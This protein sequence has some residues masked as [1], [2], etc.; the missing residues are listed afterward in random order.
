MGD[1]LMAKVRADGKSIRTLTVKVRY[2]DMDEEQA[3]VSLEEPTDLETE[4]YAEISRLLRKAWKRRVS[5]RLVSL[6][7]ANLYDGR[8]RGVLALD[9]PARQHE[10]QQR[11]ADVV[12]ALREKYGRGVVLRGHDFIL[13]VIPP[14]SPSHEPNQP[15]K[16][17]ECGSP[18]PLLE[19]SGVRKRQGTAA[20]QDAGAPSQIPGPNA[21]PKAVEAPHEP[22]LHKDG[23][24]SL[25]LSPLEGERGP[26]AGEGAVQEVEA[27]IRSGNFLPEGEGR[28]ALPLN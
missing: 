10:A 22:H 14:A 20:L 1:K 8:F 25:S 21:R 11:L 16:V 24:L 27:R 4:I 19:T 26:K 5:L 7:L 2:N 15:R 17:L 18:L 3:S 23:P 6:K 9:A 13:R 12:D 28:G